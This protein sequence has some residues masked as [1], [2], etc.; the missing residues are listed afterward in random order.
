MTT[1]HRLRRRTTRPADQPLPTT[2]SASADALAFDPRLALKIAY[3]PI[4]SLRPS[5]QNARTH[6]KKQ[7]H[8]IKASLRQFGFTNPILI[9]A[10]AEIVAGHGRFEAAKEL[11]Y[12]QVPTICLEHLSETDLRAYRIADNRLA[13]L[14]GW[15]DEILKLE[16]AY[17]TDIDM[18]LPE[19]TGFE[20][21]EIDIILDSPAKPAI[22][23]DPTDAVPDVA[24]FAV[25]RIGDLWLMAEHRVMCGDARDPQAYARLLDG[26]LAQMI[27]ADPPYNCAVNGHVG[28]LGATQHREFV[29]ASGE[30]SRPEFIGFLKAVLAELAKASQDGALHYICMDWHELSALLEAGH[31]TY[32]ELKN[33]I[34]WAKTNGGMGSLYR[35]Q[36]E[37]I[38]LWKKGRAPHINNIELGRH[39]RY[40]TNVWTYAGVNTF[41]RGRMEELASHPTVKPVAMV[42][43]AIKDCSK[44]KGIILDAFGGSG[45]TLIAAAKTKRRGYLLELDP[46]YVDVIVRRWQTL[47]RSEA[48]HAKTGLTFSEMAEQRAR[49]GRELAA[50]PNEEG[51]H[52]A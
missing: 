1:T 4:A 10:E 29:M 30:M 37:F 47:F 9:T 27:F 23:D 14:A 7:L 31:A 49:E 34:C 52:G 24:E 21:A 5:P 48:R 45:T 39:G 35:S 50:L 2:P 51:G 13:E 42:M 15:D 19:L 40:R 20:T 3:C 41:K 6:S 43:D 28:G 25:S 18:D 44:P 12:E 22:K 17:L 8:K 32:D 33:I 36:H 16:F 11:G 38:T 46:L 26:E